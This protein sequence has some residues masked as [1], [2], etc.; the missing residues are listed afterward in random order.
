MSVDTAK[1][2]TLLKASK[3]S[4]AVAVMLLIGGLG[5]I[6]IGAYTGYFPTLLNGLVLVAASSLPFLLAAKIKKKLEKL[7][8]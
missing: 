5:I 6:A 3:A 7:D 8:V 4:K 2:K 1:Q